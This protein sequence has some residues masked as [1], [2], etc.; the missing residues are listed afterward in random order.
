MGTI[1]ATTT[2]HFDFAIITINLDYKLVHLD[3]NWAQ[4]ASLEEKYVRDV[5]IYDPGKVGAVIITNE[6]KDASAKVSIS[7]IGWPQKQQ[8]KCL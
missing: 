2:N 4:V 3:Q 8:S 1:I 7:E 6:S 5:T